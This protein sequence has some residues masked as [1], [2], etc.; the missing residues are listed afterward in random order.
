M[1]KRISIIT[2]A[3]FC[4]GSHHGAIADSDTIYMGQTV[5]YSDSSSIA[6]AIL[7]DCQLPQQQA[8]LIERLAQSQGITVVRDDESVKAG[9]GRVLHVEITSA[10][11][12]GN[13][14]IGHRKQ[15]SVKGHLFEN[16]T[17]IGNFSGLRSSMGGAFAGFKGSC[18]VLG[19]CVETLAKDIALWLKN[20]TKESRIGE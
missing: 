5:P 17:E 18:S 14:F 16:G 6:Q 3:I 4:V 8:E 20:P 12:M 15:V 2:A 11:S 9:K 7:N 19:R 1:H 13:A 10:V